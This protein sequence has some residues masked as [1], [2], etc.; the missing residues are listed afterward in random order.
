LKVDVAKPKGLPEISH[1][2]KR[3]EAAASG[4]FILGRDAN[5]KSSEVW[6]AAVASPP[7]NAA[8]YG[9]GDRLAAAPRAENSRNL[10]RTPDRHLVRRDAPGANVLSLNTPD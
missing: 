9:A 8:S 5:E 1:E 10:G 6:V 4:L 7:I 2:Q 3:P